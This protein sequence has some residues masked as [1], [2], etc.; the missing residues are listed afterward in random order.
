VLIAAGAGFV[1]IPR[2]PLIKVILYSQVANGVL[3]PFVLIFMLKLVNREAIMGEYR[4]SL[5]ANVI[6]WGTSITLILLTVFW[7]VTIFRG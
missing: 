1:L 3:L 7:V 6:A 4:N 2:L 5:V